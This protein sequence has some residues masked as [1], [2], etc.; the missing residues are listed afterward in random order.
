MLRF[1]LDDGQFEIEGQTA[2]YV[3]LKCA[4]WALLDTTPLLEYADRT[5][6]NRRLPRGTIR[7]FRR[8]PTSKQ[9]S[10]PFMLT[11]AVTPAGDDNVNPYTGFE[12]NYG[13][14]VDE[15]V[16]DP[17]TLAGTRTGRYTTASGDVRT[18]RVQVLDVP[19][20][21]GEQGRYRATLELVLVDGMLT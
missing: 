18:G 7:A 19:L 15:L 16:A 2:G 9:L 21:D 20:G 17:G 11:G 4:A 10:M 1:C 6:R 5:G 3:S 14:L 13:F 8:R 12:D